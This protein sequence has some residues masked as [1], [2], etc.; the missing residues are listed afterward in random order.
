MANKQHFSYKAY[1][2]SIEFS[3]EDMC[4][5]GKIQ[6]IQDLVMYD[7]KTLEEL[8]LS[9]ESAVDEYLEMCAEEN[10]CPDKP[11]SGTFNVRMSESMHRKS[12]HE[13][14]ILGITLNS[15]I[16][17]CV[18]NYFTENTLKDSYIFIDKNTFIEQ[19]THPKSY[20]TVGSEIDF[21][22]DYSVKPKTFTVSKAVQ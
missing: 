5:F 20:S 7:G 19:F 15:F 22:Y 16:S 10:I 3:T 13:S 12:I 21:D 11:C 6:M 18:E 8:K 14:N 4:L 2:G 1:T 9:F 17:K